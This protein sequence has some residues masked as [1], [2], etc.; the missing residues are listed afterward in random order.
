MSPLTHNR[1]PSPGLPEGVGNRRGNRPA[2]RRRA[3]SVIEL[4]LAIV[5]LGVIIYALYHVFNQTQ[6]A[7]R[8]AEKQTDVSGRARAVLEMIARELEQ[9]QPTRSAVRTERGLLQEVN[10]LGGLE[11][12]PR[13]QFSDRRD[14]QGRTNF[15]HNLFFYTN[16]TN[17]WQGI[18]YRVIDVKN[19]VGVLQ[20]FETNQFGYKPLSNVLSSAF[21]NEP[22]TNAT[23]H[24]VADGVIHFSVIPYDRKGYRLGYDT[25]TRFADGYS[26]ISTRADGTPIPEL[27]DTTVTNL[28]NVLLQ[29]GFPDSRAET[30]PYWSRFAF[31]SNAMPAYVEVELAILEPDTLSQY[32]LML[33]DQ[34]PNA[35]KFLERQISKVHLYRERVPVRTAA[36]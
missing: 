12:P 7:L 5:I 19:G 18:G 14:I 32:Y 10:L 27:S 13:A 36:Q 31:K 15:L 24:H 29:E 28:A 16:R 34:N 22:L 20:R 17:A 1:F 23:Y 30:L 9:A 4:M 11:Y 35:G 6:R 33:E 25:G 21:I 8:T 3:F 26:I 2:G